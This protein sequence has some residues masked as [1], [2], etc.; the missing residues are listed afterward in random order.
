[1]TCC[2]RGQHIHTYPN[3]KAL[4]ILQ[5]LYLHY[6]NIFISKFLQHVYY[7]TPFVNHLKY[8]GVTMT[9]GLHEESMKNY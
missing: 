5:Y 7:Y 6:L 9:E 3:N 4:T 8:D 1:M 2:K